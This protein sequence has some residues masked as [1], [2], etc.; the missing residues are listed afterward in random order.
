[1]RAVRGARALRRCRFAS[2]RQGVKIFLE[3]SPP[4]AD[5]GFSLAARQLP[6]LVD[7][8]GRRAAAVSSAPPHSPSPRATAPLA[9][10]CTIAHS[11]RHSFWCTAAFTWVVALRGLGEAWVLCTRCSGDEWSDSAGAARVAARPAACDRR[12][13]TTRAAQPAVVR[14]Q[15]HGRERLGEPR[16]DSPWWTKGCRPCTRRA[17]PPRLGAAAAV[18]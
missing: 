3:P 13:G 12:E 5:S 10:A 6:E 4:R 15:R 7:A 8:E 1:M 18:V 2:R 9:A 16:G 11:R 14:S 17:R